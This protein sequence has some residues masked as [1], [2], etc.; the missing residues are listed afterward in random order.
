MA[1]VREFYKIRTDGVSLYRTYSDA[2][3]LIVQNETGVEYDV[4][5]DVEDAP[6]TYTETDK[7]IEGD[8]EE[9]TEEDYIAALAEL[10]VT[11][12]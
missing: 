12:E 1:I 10:G 7:P 6:Y 9:A 4:A 5:I 3:L 11:E 2:D 8:T